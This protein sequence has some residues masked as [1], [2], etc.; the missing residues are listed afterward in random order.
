MLNSSIESAVMVS[1]A[2]RPSEKPASA[3]AETPTPE[4]EVLV[5]SSGRALKVEEAPRPF[6]RCPFF[7]GQLE[8]RQSWWDA[9]AR[10]ALVSDAMR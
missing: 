5:L 10:D 4:I 2:R 6:Q 3:P 1:S 9:V 7:L 8:G